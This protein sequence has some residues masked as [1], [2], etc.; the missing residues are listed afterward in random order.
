MS[1]REVQSQ[2]ERFMQRAE[3][4]QLLG[5]SNGALYSWILRDLFPRPVQLGPLR[6]TGK[7]GRV[8]WLESEV[9]AWINEKAAQPRV[10]WRADV[11]NNQSA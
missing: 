5:I 8:A 3:V 2:P 9:R 1:T 7:A 6:T 4:L 11:V 10:V